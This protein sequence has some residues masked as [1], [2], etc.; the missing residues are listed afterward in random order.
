[1]RSDA[2]DESDVFVIQVLPIKDATTAYSRKTD[3][4]MSSYHSYIKELTATIVINDE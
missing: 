2:T 4:P 3:R 1:M